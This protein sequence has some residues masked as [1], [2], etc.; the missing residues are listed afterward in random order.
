MM[1][2]ES[3]RQSVGSDNPWARL[4]YS[5]EVCAAVV[6]SEGRMAADAL[7]VRKLK[8]PS[9]CNSHVGVLGCLLLARSC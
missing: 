1:V 7:D 9:Q 6:A 8:N 2:V 5:E 3:L 4:C